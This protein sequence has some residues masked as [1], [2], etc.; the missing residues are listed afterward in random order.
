[1][2]PHFKRHMTEWLA[3]ADTVV[4]NTFNEFE[5]ETLD[6]MCATFPPTAPIH[7]IGLLTYSRPSL[8]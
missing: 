2:P 6:T 3:K 5:P 7:T 1:M 4:L 8:R